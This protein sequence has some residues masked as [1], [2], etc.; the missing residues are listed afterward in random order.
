MSTYLR[1]LSPTKTEAGS[2]DSWLLSRPRTLWGGGRENSQAY[3]L[4]QC[5]LLVSIL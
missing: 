5:Q 4:S 2:E 3:N 1:A